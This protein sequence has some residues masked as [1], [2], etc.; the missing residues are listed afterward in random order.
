MNSAFNTKY[1][2]LK[3]QVV[4][5]IMKKLVFIIINYIKLEMKFKNFIILL[6]KNL[7]VEFP[8]KILKQYTSFWALST[9][10]VL[11]LVKF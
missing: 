4:H 10:S 9:E 6:S 2:T 3:S 8:R 5:Q 7:S 11:K 1:S